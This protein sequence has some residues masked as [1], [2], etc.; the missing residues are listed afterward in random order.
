MPSPHPGRTF[1]GG[2][3]CNS[4]TAGGGK[5]SSGPGAC[6]LRVPRFE[7]D[8]SRSIEYV[9][10]SRTLRR[11]NVDQPE[12]VVDQRKFSPSSSHVAGDFWVR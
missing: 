11:G 3:R 7:Q 9:R 1:E 6:S 10:S 2:S 12:D 4:P 5:P 8:Q